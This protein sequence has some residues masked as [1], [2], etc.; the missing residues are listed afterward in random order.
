[1]KSAPISCSAGISRG[2]LKG[3]TRPTGPH[4]QRMPWLIC[5]AWSPDT[6]ND[7]AMNLGCMAAANLVLIVSESPSLLEAHQLRG[8]IA[9][10]I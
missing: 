8:S 9:Q 2:K 3:V 4:G 5:P 10:R 1:M 6:P 7:L